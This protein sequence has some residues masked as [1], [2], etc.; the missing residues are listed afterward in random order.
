[1][2]ERVSRA[3]SKHIREKL[4]QALTLIYVCLDLDVNLLLPCI[5]QAF[6]DIVQ[7]F[8][9]FLALSFEFLDLFLK[10]HD[11]ESLILLKEGFG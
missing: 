8:L 6:P 3:I 7:I 10:R 2:V 11:K 1:M 5:F 4:S 9:L